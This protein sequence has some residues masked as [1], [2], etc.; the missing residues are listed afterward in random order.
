MQSA[1][2]QRLPLKSYLYRVIRENR[3]LVIVTLI[4]TNTLTLS[5][6]NGGDYLYG[7]LLLPA[8][9]SSGIIR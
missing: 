5:E 9:E 7:S 4:E 2:P 3:F 1:C 8:Y 6:V